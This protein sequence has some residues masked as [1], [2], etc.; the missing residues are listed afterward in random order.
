VNFVTAAIFTLIGVLI[1]QISLHLVEWTKSRRERERAQRERE[2]S[3]KRETYLPLMSAFTEAIT[4]FLSLPQ[5]HYNKLAEW[6]L[7]TESQRSLAVISLIANEPVMNAVNKASKQLALG[8]VRLMASKMDEAKLAIELEAIE[9]Q[10]KQFNEANAQNLSRLKALQDASKLTPEIAKSI[11]SDFQRTAAELQQLFAQQTAKSDKRFQIMKDLQHQSLREVVELAR[12]S[13]DATIAIRR[14]LELPTDP[15]VL[16][17]YLRDAIGFA[18]EI[19]P[20]LIDEI[21]QRAE[22]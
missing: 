20:G 9:S 18:D 19:F 10:I 17:R 12:F 14:D 11:D 8:T 21:W 2:L 5:I 1:A 7:S 6:K 13:L 22:G 16:E 3:L 15:V 4:L